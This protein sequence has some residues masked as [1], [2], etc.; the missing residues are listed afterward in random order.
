MLEGRNDIERI[1]GRL[2]ASESEADSVL[3]RRAERG[4]RFSAREAVRLRGPDL[5]AIERTYE[6]VR[7]IHAQAYH[8]DPP[9]LEPIAAAR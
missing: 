9:P 4:M 3:A 6:Q 2:R 5:P 7:T 8:W 1:P